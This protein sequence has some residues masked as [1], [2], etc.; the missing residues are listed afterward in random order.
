MQLKDQVVSLD[1]SKRLKELG[2]KQEGLWWW[3][4]NNRYSTLERLKDFP[5]NR[6]WG[7]R[8][9][10]IDDKC[11]IAPTCAELGITLPEYYKTIRKDGMWG[12]YDDNGDGYVE[13]ISKTEVNSRA[14]MLIY[15]LENK[16]M[17]L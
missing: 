7:L 4:Y 2:Y 15:L 9:F 14:S 17:E 10:K 5:D 1:L 12:C 13:T 16:L 6:T 11:L 8:D 3:E